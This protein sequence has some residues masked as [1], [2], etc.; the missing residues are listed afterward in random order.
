MLRLLAILLCLVATLLCLVVFLLWFLNVAA[1]MGAAAGVIA[2]FG[3]KSPNEEPERGSQRPNPIRRWARKL[4]RRSGSR[5]N[6]KE[7]IQVLVGENARLVEENTMLQNANRDL[8]RELRSKDL[9]P[10]KYTVEDSNNN[11]S[12]PSEQA[13][14]FGAN[15]RNLSP[16]QVTEL[17]KKI[18]KKQ[19]ETLRRGTGEAKRRKRQ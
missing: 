11:Q 18:N 14:P 19:R 2:I 16:N 9:E 15:A 6:R 8:Q 3:A 17:Y 5:A 12:A 13:T 1:F 10:P 7:K 4:G